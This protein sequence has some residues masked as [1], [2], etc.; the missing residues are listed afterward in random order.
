VEKK[1]EK[2]IPRHDPSNPLSPGATRGS[3]KT[4]PVYE[5]VYVFDNDFPALL[6]NV[7]SPDPPSHPL[8]KSESARGTCRVLCFHPYSDLTLPLMSVSEIRAVVDEWAKQTEELGQTFTWVQVFEN[9]GEL[10][11]CS[12][13]H[14]HCQIW[15]SSFLPNEPT[16]EDYNQKKY[17]SEYG[18]PLLVEYA[19]LEAKEKE[20]IVVEN[21]DWLVVVPYWAAWPYETLLMPKRRHILRLPDLTDSERDALCDIMKR[22][23]TKYDNLFEC[24]FPYSMGWHGAPTGPSSKDQDY[25]HWQLHA[26]YYPCL[27]RSATVSLPSRYYVLGVGVLVYIN[28]MLQWS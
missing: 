5:G 26:H 11:G 10:M 6:P 16:R 13:P 1:E 20:R 4:N 28:C 3:G 8:L 15:T 2:E 21:E 27:L 18:K 23:L 19:E 17:L 24:S 9:K 7:P 12:N 22:L 25:S 14:P